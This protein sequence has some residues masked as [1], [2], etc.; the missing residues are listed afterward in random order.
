MRRQDI[1]R[2]ALRLFAERGIASVSTRDIAAEVGCGESGLYRHMKSKEELAI[3][4]FS[5]AYGAFADRLRDAISTETTF[6]GRVHAIISE[7][8]TSFDEDPILLR[9]LVLRQHDGI[10]AAALGENNPVDVV[11]QC[12]VSA[13]ESGDIPNLP[14]E[15]ALPI[16]MG[17]ALQPLTNAL[18]GRLP[19]PLAPLSPV[20]A[21]AALRALE[22]E[23]S[24]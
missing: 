17:I 14:A 19:M 8:Y 2:A 12:I 6:A 10:P 22:V 21:T 3:R 11:Y 16:L 5:E 7:I 24:S 13:S 20:I 4:V 18:Y 1:E 9:F 23:F 15:V